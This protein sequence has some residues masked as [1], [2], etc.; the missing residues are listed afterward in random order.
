MAEVYIS[1]EIESAESFGDNRLSCYWRLQIGG[2]EDQEAG[3][4]PFQEVVGASWREKSRAKHKQIS[5]PAS[6]KPILLTL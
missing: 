3:G 1:G 2:L 6:K 4:V 5:L